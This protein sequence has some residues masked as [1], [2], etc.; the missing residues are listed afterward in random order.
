MLYFPYR[1]DAREIAAR[2]R[3]S[4]YRT[5]GGTEMQNRITERLF[6]VVA[7]F[8]LFFSFVGPA[9]AAQD[10]DAA[11]KVRIDFNTAFNNRDAQA[12]SLLIDQDAV[13]MAPGLAAVQGKAK[14]DEFYREYFK[15]MRSRI[16]LKAGD[17]K[18][19]G[20]W[21]FLDALFTRVDAPAKGKRLSRWTGHYM[22]VLKKQADGSWKIARDIWNDAPSLKK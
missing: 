10:T 16:D 7:V 19:C 12:L 17:I 13:I 15:K 14:V 9:V 11:D 2:I 3:D 4:K 18:L 5:C 20:D 21:A 8:V 22:F 6:P 1:E